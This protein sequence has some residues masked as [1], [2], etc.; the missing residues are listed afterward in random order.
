MKKVMKASKKYIITIASFAVI[1]VACI[2]ATIGITMAYFGDVKS[3][4]ANITLGASIAFDGTNG[5]AVAAGNTTAVPSQVVNVTTTLKIVAGAKGT[6]TNGVLEVTP[7]FSAGKTG[8]TCTFA[9]GTK[10]AV[11]GVTGATMIAQ[12]NKL[13]L[14]DSNTTTNLKEI[15]PTTSGITISFVVPVTIP[16]TIGNTAGGEQCSL[17]MTAKVLQSTIY[18]DADTTVGKTVTEFATYFQ[19]FTAAA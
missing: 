1:L 13:Y 4:S 18:T 19:N 12:N 2:G 10:Y 15:T 7:T 14:V 6:V 16:S 17:S 5:I 8:A 3:S 9:N 11:T